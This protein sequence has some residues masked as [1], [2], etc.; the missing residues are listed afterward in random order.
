MSEKKLEAVHT[1][2]IFSEVKTKTTISRPSGRTT[3][4]YFQCQNHPVDS[5][6]RR[7]PQTS[8]QSRGRSQLR[9]PE[10]GLLRRI[11]VEPLG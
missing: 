3:T 8:I 1:I 4:W 10:P 6:Y 11:S 2:K 7:D 5:G 9:H